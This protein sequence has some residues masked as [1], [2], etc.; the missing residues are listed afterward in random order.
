MDNQT[1]RLNE[2]S[3]PLPAQASAT[4][5]SGMLILLSELAQGYGAPR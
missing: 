4:T 5:G 2:I 1:D 3:I